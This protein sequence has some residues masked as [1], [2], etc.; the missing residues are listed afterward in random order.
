MKRIT[1]LLTL[2]FLFALTSLGKAQELDCKVNIVTTK[3][4]SGD[5]SVFETLSTVLN[6]FMNGRRWTNLN[7]RPQEKIPCS[8]TIDV[9]EYNSGNGQVK[10][11]LTVQL[12]RP[13]YK[14]T[15]TSLLLNTVDKDFSF[16]YVKNDPIEFSDNSIGTNLTATLAFYAY[17]IL[18][19]YFD[20]FAPRGGS[21]F[22]EKAN[23]I[24][25]QAQGMSEQGWRSSERNEKNRYWI[26][27]SYSNSNYQA[28]HEVL[29]RYFRLGMDM[30]F[31]DPATAR[32]NILE[33]LSQLDDLKR[34]RP[35]LP[36]IQL[37]MESRADELVNI[38]QP[39]EQTERQKA[40]DVL[41][42]IDAANVNTY[43][44]IL[45]NNAR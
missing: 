12:R 11:Y 13:V 20:S 1:A 17:L 25:L 36:C 31:D 33:A 7:F 42:S 41:V 9:Q 14:S 5:K 18:G 6:Q 40:F 38:F 44:K 32:V 37:F 15:Y 3:V 45:G 4:T 2:A 39:A 35:S 30:M 43:K 28:I 29:Y 34:K 16:S 8:M 22:Y 10:A 21:V 27:E 23:N 19:N 26:S 24:V